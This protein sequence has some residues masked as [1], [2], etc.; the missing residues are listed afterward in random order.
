MT[1]VFEITELEIEIGART[2]AV[3]V[4][5][6]LS[7]AV[8]KGETLVVVG[9]SGSGKSVG[10]MT[11]LRLLPNP[12]FR[13]TAGTVR[14]KGEDVMAMPPREWRRLAGREVGMVFQDALASLNPVFTV[15]WQISE[16]L[17]VQGMSRATA[18][19]K[20]IQLMQHIGIP[21]AERR[22]SAFPHQF[23][24]GMRQRIMIAIAL[25]SDPTLLVC[26]EPTTALDV[27]IQAQIL[28]LL[29]RYQ[30]ESHTAMI[31]VT[32]DLGVA[33]EIADR[34]AVVYAGR[35]VESGRSDDVLF[36]PIHPYTAALLAASPSEEEGHMP[37]PIPGAAPHLT[38]RPLGCPFAPRCGH[39]TDI[40]RTAPPPEVGGNG[41]SALCHHA[42]RVP[43]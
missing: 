26:D 35:V 22:Y 6:G 14:F 5:N 15:G 29:R 18:R 40:C 23:S 7:Y 9:E 31:M 36:N 17:R 1:S 19:Q 10:L 43:A 24:G 3:H 41:H 34:L 39:A 30:R 33:S 13:V 16:R 25:A 28:D 32:H 2:G 11:A 37:Q 21:D 38:E 8:A 12:P 27:T 4:A 42:L 20:A